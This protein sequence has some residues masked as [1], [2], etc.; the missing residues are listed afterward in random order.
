MILNR[1]VGEV[2]DTGE[3]RAKAGGLVRWRSAG[4]DEREANA[5]RALHAILMS[6]SK[7]PQRSEI[8]DSRESSERHKRHQ[9]ES[10]VD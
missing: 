5:V 8:S 4:H 6:P 7:N 3:E 9:T 10:Q 2:R 1:I